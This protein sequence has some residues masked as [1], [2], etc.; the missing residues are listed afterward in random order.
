MLLFCNEST[1]SVYKMA[2]SKDNQ[3]CD[4]LALSLRSSSVNGP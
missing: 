4:P 1:P 3:F 2:R